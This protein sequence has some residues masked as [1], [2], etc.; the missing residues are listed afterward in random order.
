MRSVCRL[1][2]FVTLAAVLVPDHAIAEA[3]VPTKDI[4]SARDN[5]L[6][7]RY[8]GSFIVDYAQKEFDEFELP[9]AELKQVT[10][11]KDT[12]NND[13]F[14]PTTAET[15]EGRLTRIVYVAPA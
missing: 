3:T 7:R 10:G 14:A 8:D 5:P 2:L 1:V 6:L 11:K 15:L 4:A 13:V 12:K 9:T